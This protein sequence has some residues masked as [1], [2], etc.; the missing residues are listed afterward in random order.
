M[1]A[2]PRNGVTIGVPLFNEERHVESA[3]RSAAPQGEVVL[4]SD[5]AST[6]GSAAICARV[7]GEQP[8]VAYVKQPENIG[9]VANFKYV[10]D[11][12]KTRYF[13]WLGSHDQLPEGYVETLLARL[14]RDPHAVM[15]FGFTRYIDVEGSTTGRYDYAYARRLADRAPSARTLALIRYLDDCSL[16][17]GVFR[18]DVLRAAW[19][20]S[21]PS[22]RYLGFDHVLLVNAALRGP[23][24]Y[25]PSTCLIRRNVHA[26][27][28]AAARMKRIEG[29]GHAGETSP[30]PPSHSTM[31]REQYAVVASLAREAGPAGLLLRLRA[32]FHLVSRF[33]SFGDTLVTS[34]LD[35]LLQARLVRTSMT[36]LERLL[37]V[38]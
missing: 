14:E 7:S 24:I 5:N 21:G 17:H 27:D 33:G 26:A 30:A 34:G 35:R 10:L 16:I 11:Q 1:T 2:P 29:R 22:L 19:E 20:A 4:V 25:A 13:M 28:T 32:R 15:A 6:D 38:S 9:A 8:S 23:F 12:A 36:E 37:E 18:T 31:Q 3:L